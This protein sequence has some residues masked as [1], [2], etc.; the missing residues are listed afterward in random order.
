[1]TKLIRS[2]LFYVIIFAQGFGQLNTEWWKYES[3]HFLVYF[4]GGLDWE[5]NQLITSLELHPNPINESQ[6]YTKIKTT[7]ILEEGGAKSRAWF[8]PAESLVH[9]Y[10]SSSPSD[11]LGNFTTD[12]IR[13]TALH[14]FTH[15]S[16]INTSFGIANKAVTI[17][18]PFL[19]PNIFLPDWIVEGIAISKESSTF[20]NEGMLNSGWA[21]AMVATQA[22][23]DILPNATTVPLRSDEPTE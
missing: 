14:E 5:A 3:D 2:I 1:M 16:H 21:D 20:K 9:Q 4:P 12:Q 11:F 6:K 17:F 22:K 23:Y 10:V 19:H 15:S 8:N 18:G 7:Y 13:S